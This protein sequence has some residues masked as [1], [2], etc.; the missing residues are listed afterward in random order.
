VISLHDVSS[1]HV[2]NISNI[3]SV[4]SCLL[5]PSLSSNAC[6]SHICWAAIMTSYLAQFRLHQAPS[7][8]QVMP[9]SPPS[10]P[11]VVRTPGPLRS[12]TRAQ[13][14]RRVESSDSREAECKRLKT[15]ATG[16][17]KTNGLPEDS[18]EQFA[19]VSEWFK[20]Q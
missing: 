11:L 8:P 6:P 1:C 14:R 2:F 9:S 18:L 5:S 17:C 4:N 10:S 12:A 13:V 20:S 7:L 15:Y 19:A 3:V 16:I